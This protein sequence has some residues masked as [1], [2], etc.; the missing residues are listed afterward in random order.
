MP[1]GTNARAH[2]TDAGVASAS[3]AGVRVGR[4]ADRQH[5]GGSGG[6]G[7]GGRGRGRG[8]GRG[9]GGEYLH[10]EFEGGRS[11]IDYLSRVGEQEA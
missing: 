8:Q 5:H 4:R 6:G 2:A 1:V 9:H 3:T 11:L 7:G 10:V